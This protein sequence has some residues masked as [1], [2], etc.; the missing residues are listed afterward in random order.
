MVRLAVGFLVLLSRPLASSSFHIPTF[1]SVPSSSLAMSQQYSLP[2]QA[3]RFA[4]AKKENNQ[5]F[6]DVTSV[7]DPSFLK[8]KRV[9]V[10]GANRGIGLALATELT[11]AGAKLVALV[12]SSSAELEAL[13]PVEI[14]KGIDVTDDAGCAKIHEKISG[15]PI[16]I[17]RTRSTRSQTSKARR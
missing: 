9:A 3:A 7:Y 16:D 8:G 5:R 11:A 13:N 15:G 6:L 14:V 10:T 12:R 1:S 17:V 4:Q 2:D